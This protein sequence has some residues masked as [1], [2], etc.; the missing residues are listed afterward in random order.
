M[1]K[2][3]AADAFSTVGVPFLVS[4]TELACNDARQIQP[5]ANAWSDSALGAYSAALSNGQREASSLF[6]ID[7]VNL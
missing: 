6:A 4:K 2:E 1:G 7:I 5:V 3:L